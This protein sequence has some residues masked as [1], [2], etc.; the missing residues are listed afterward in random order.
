MVLGDC[1]KTTD[2]VLSFLEEACAQQ[3][4]IGLNEDDDD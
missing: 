1:V 4:D 3:W 2:Q